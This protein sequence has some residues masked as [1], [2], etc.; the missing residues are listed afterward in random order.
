MDGYQRF[1]L[2]RQYSAHRTRIKKMKPFVDTS[3]PRT[4]GLMDRPDVK[5]QLMEEQRQ[6]L[7]EQNNNILQ[8][9]LG[10]VSKGK[11]ADTEQVKKHDRIGR[12][13]QR[14]HQEGRDMHARRIAE[15]NQRYA[16][17]IMRYRVHIESEYSQNHILMAPPK[18]FLAKGGKV[19]IMDTP[20]SSRPGSSRPSSS[21][22]A[23]PSSARS[24]RPNTPNNTHP[25]RPARRLLLCLLA[26]SFFREDYSVSCLVDKE[27]RG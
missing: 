7:I 16:K 21:A 25:R 1:E 18:R 22:R 14:F 9:A 4:M 8:D 20:P 24:S 27:S 15:E 23:T 5:K 6:K 12:Q 3:K 2:I 19:S 10:K 17:G 13:M 11:A 26:F